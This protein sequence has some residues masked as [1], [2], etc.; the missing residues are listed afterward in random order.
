MSEGPVSTRRPRRLVT[1]MTAALIGTVILTLL[2]AACGGSPGSHVAQPGPTT[3]EGSTPSAAAAQNGVLAFSQCM[4]S[5]GVPDFPDPNSSGVLPK[6]QIARLAASSPQF[7]AAH[8]A[9]G[10]LLPNGGQPTQAQAQQAWSDMRKFARCMR[11][12]GIPNWPDPAPTSPQDSR[13]FFHLPNSMDPSAP[14][15]VSKIRACQHVMHTSNPLVT[16][17]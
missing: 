10:H 17:Q 6:S 14:Q 2:A 4:R 12:H 3:T 13:P 9:C 8:R 11:L 16:T 5:H 1:R 7:P 15:L